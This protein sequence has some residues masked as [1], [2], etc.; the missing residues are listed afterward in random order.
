[1]STQ[2]RTTETNRP[3]P[4]ADD[5]APELGVEPDLLERFVDAHPDP[6]APIV[7]G[8]ATEHGRLSREPAA[9]REPVAAYLDARDRSSG[10]TVDETPVADVLDPDRSR[11]PSA[12]ALRRVRICIGLSQQEAA[13]RTGVAGSTLSEWENENKQ[14][15]RE[16]REALLELYREVARGET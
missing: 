6:T 7:L 16:R 9:L 10:R 4:T 1:M 5:L 11:L 12:D 13:S 2:T 3:T 8:W 15:S 14:M